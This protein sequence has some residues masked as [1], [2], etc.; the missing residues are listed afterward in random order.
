MA[1]LFVFSVRDIGYRSIYKC[2]LMGT[3]VQG[4]HLSRGQ[5]PPVHHGSLDSAFYVES[6]CSELNDGMQHIIFKR[7]GRGGHAS[8]SCLSHSLDR[9]P[10]NEEKIKHNCY[11]YEKL[12]GNCYLF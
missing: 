6:E 12:P 7:T 4:G 1:N 9:L 8:E 3:N 2:W 10:D 11:K 5:S